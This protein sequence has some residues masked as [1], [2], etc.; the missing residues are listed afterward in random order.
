MSGRKTRMQGS[1]S[2]RADLGR[3]ASG[4]YRLVSWVFAHEAVNEVIFTRVHFKASAQTVWNHLVLYEEVPGR[5]PFLLR[6]LLPHP[7][8]TEGEKTRVG[9][10]VR[11]AYQGSYLVK[12]ITA[13]EPPH[14]LRFE[15]VEQH[16]GIEDC[17]LTQSGSYEIHACG[18]AADMVLVTN[19]QA[20]LRPRY[21]WRPLEALLVSQLH[22]HILRGINTALLA[23]NPLRRPAVAEPFEAECALPGDLACTA[24][25]SVSRR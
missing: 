1:E 18:E 6:T 10:T 15:V 3:A 14:L 16:L 20:Y 24:F 22:R 4:R 25:Q 2:A 7:L 5:P 13:V 17:V 19:Y 11:C 21:L 12:R 23:S 8:R 9:A